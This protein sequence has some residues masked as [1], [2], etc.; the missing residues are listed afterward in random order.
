VNDWIVWFFIVLV[1]V[2]QI[3]LIWTQGKLLRLEQRMRN[4]VEDTLHN[5]ACRGEHEVR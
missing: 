4:H 2:T 3:S 1:I 5:I